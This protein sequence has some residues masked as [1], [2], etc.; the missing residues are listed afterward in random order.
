MANLNFKWGLHENLPK[1]KSPGTVYITTNGKQM[2]VDLDQTKRIR[3]QGTVHYYEDADDFTSSATPPYDTNILYFFKKFTFKNSDNTS[4]QVTNALMSYDGSKWHQIN[5]PAATLDSV[6]TAISSLNTNVAALTETTTKLQSS[7]NDH[8]TRIGKIEKAVGDTNS[9]LTTRVTT[10]EKDVKDLT[11]QQSVIKNDINGLT[12]AVGSLQAN[13]ATKTEL[14][15][16]ADSSALTE[17]IS[18]TTEKFNTIDTQIA[19][20]NSSLSTKADQTTVNGISSAIGQIQT[21][22]NEKASSES[23]QELSATVAQKANASDVVSLRKEFSSSIANKANSSDVSALNTKVLGLETQVNN[24]ADAT[25]VNDL[26]NQV[27]GKADASALSQAKTELEEK[28]NLKADASTVNTLSASVETLSGQVAN[29]VDTTKFN[30]AVDNFAAS[31]AGKVST[32]AFNELKTSVNSKADASTVSTLSTSVGTLTSQV[33]NKL[34]TTTFN[35]KVQQLNTSIDKKA[36]KSTVETLRTTVNSKAD[37]ETVSKL[38][39]AVTTLSSSLDE[40]AEKTEVEALETSLNAKINAANALVYKGTLN[41]VD[42]TLEKASIGDLYVWTG[43]VIE[44]SGVLPGDLIVI[45]CGNSDIGETN[46]EIPLPEGK[47]YF[48]AED[49]EYDVIP[50]GYGT[51]LDQK[52]VFDDTN[53]NFYISNF[54]NEACGAKIQ[55][56]VDS[57]NLSVSFNKV[58]DSENGIITI[59]N[60]WASFDPVVES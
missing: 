53:N 36:D 15:T 7:V 29:K 59:S 20:V 52:L 22:L 56:N 37:A 33:A 30:E 48:D 28:I 3:I 58:K 18:T 12:S 9:S 6:L 34:D 41:K 43:E 16:K 8:E 39:T 4:T 24:K 49:L 1:A 54:K 55:I 60:S 25:T 50:T 10:L 26:S 38:N 46:G 42:F 21:A 31:L 47:T 23:V 44:D 13:A 5:T 35:T 2:Y 32:T 11:S 17:H 45:K 40:K 14:A 57:D 27:S 19:E 51:F